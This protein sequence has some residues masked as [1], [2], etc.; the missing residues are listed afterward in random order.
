VT[1]VPGLPCG[2]N[3]DDRYC[4]RYWE[5]S[6]EVDRLRL[7]IGELLDA[8]GLD[9]AERT[10]WLDR[11]RLSESAVYPDDDEDGDGDDAIQADLD[12]YDAEGDL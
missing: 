12:A 8:T 10:E 6:A 1:A 9:D 7:L 5:L 4:E 11:N 2:P 3:A